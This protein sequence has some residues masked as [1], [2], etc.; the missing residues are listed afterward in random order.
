TNFFAFGIGSS[1]NRYLIEGV[2][3]AGQGEPFIVTSPQEADAAGARFREYI[4]SPV[5]TNVRVN[6]H[7]FDTYDVEPG[8]PPALFADRPVVVFGKWRGSKTGQI[9]VT[10][11]TAKGTFTKVFDVGDSVSRPEHAALP[12]LWART[13]IARLSDFGYQQNDP[14]V[15]REVTN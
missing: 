8:A 14:A 9:E 15:V 6:Y 10:G 3:R 11:R 4:E 12:Q 7:G 1:V 5:L 13:R 2:A